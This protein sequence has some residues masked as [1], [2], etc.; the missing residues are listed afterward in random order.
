MMFVASVSTILFNGNPLLRFDAYYV[1]S[2]LIEI[3]NLSQRAK[4]YIYF[5]IKTYC[6]GVRAAENPAHTPGERVW[7]LFY[8]LASTAYRVFICIRILL[9]LND[10]LPEQLLFLVVIF[11]A[12]AVIA[13]GLVPLGKFVKYLAASPELSRNRARAVATTLLALGLTIAG[14]GV[15]PVPDHCRVEGIVEPV[16][17]AVVYAESDGFVESCLPS[18]R[19]VSPGDEPLLRAVNPEL[20]AEKKSVLAELRALHIERRLAETRETVAAQILDERIDALQEKVARIERD[21]AS[22]HLA[23][24]LAGTWI[25]PDAEHLK[26]TYLRRGQEIGFVADLEELRI[27]ATA[28]QDLAA[29]IVEHAYKQLEVRVKGRP[30]VLVGGEIEKICPAGLEELPSESLGYAAGGTMPTLPQDSRGI[31]AAERF[32]EVLIQPDPQ[33]TGSLFARQRVV[34]RITLPS[35]PLTAQWWRSLRQLL[36][37]RFR[38]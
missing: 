14:L 16:R 1:L 22:L 13:W 19:R 6:W 23:P 36:Q 7:F 3:P 18:G 17:E 25:A 9:F 31:R 20:E 15:I 38:I 2:D 26:G 27:R 24:P 4:N 8:G 28:G 37:R 30:D 33:S 35:K 10:R 12:A 5:L 32:F 21:I 29:L 34:A 11:G